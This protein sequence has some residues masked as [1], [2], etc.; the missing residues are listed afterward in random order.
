M[1][2][3]VTG[4]IIGALIAVGGLLF[5]LAWTGTQPLDLISPGRDDGPPAVLAGGLV[6]SLPDGTQPTS[7]ALGP[8]GDAYFIDAATG[9]VRLVNIKSGKVYQIVGPGDRADGA[10]RAIGRPTQ[11]TG[12]GAEVVIVD[13]SRHAWSWRPQGRKGGGTLAPLQFQEA[14]VLPDGPAAAYDPQVGDYRL[15][16]VDAAAHQIIRFQQTLGGSSFSAPS[17]YL[18]RPDAGVDD[19]E[20]LYLDFDLYALAGDEIQ[21]YQYGR[22]DWM[23]TPQDAGAGDYRLLAG[24]GRQSSEGR[25]YVYDARD[26][27]IIGVA[28]ADGSRVASWQTGDG[29]MH[30]VRGMYVIEGGLNKKGVRKHDTLVWITPSGL[31]QARLRLPDPT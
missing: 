9:S 20:Q 6:T 26:D 3:V 17:D 13:D 7:L 1:L 4:L 30:D 24:S 14:E 29:S 23:W 27:R 11:L 5:V 31:Y 21:R 12:A 28:K 19:I 22:R 16:V 25:L 2:A 10:E 15:Y 8:K 18:V